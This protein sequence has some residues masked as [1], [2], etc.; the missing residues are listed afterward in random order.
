M[1]RGLAAVR[2]G[3]APRAAW[4]PALA[5]GMLA[6]AAWAFAL[7]GCA[8]G[9][10][11]ADGAGKPAAVR[12][13]KSKGPS[14]SDAAVPL[15]SATVLLWRFDG[16]LGTRIM[17][18]GPGALD[19]VA[20]ADTRPE[21]GRIQGARGFTRS[22][23]S[24]VWA[25]YRAALDCPAGLTVEAWIR[26]DA[27]GQYEDT[28]IASRW[29]PNTP[30]QCWFFSVGGSNLLPP[31]ATLPSPG[32]HAA[33]IPVGFQ[34]RTLAKLMFAYQPAEA[35]PARA[36][37]SSQPL[38]LD[39][40]THVAATFDGKTVR[41][42]LNGRLDSQ[43]AVRG[44]IRPSEAPLLVGNA[45]DTRSLTGFG[46]DLRVGS[47]QDRNPYYAFEGAIDELRITNV[48]RTDFPYVR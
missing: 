4:V 10:G 26:L 31:V 13:Q 43:Y 22:I 45:F 37:F 29:I 17:D 41:F 48:A 14:R 34:N 20:G 30:D 39:R 7:G 33:L 28:P 1:N 9:G 24:F 12:A 35:G 47:D 3:I 23:E 15:D 42:Y 36:F 2:F 5:A 11:A 25:P 40:W 27:F 8:A 16:A 18:E 38:E 21:L 46:G 32:D 6:L 19:G 44:T